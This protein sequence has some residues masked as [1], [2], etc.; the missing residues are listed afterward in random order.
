MFINYKVPQVSSEVFYLSEVSHAS[1]LKAEMRSST[2][3]LTAK[4]K[5]SLKS[6]KKSIPRNQVER[7]IDGHDGLKKN[8][9][10][11]QKA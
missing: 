1:D 10:H 8:F 6:L 4:E 7:I 9:F 5:K 3:N 11:F 2:Q